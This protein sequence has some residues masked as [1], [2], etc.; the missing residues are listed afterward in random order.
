MHRSFLSGVSV[1]YFIAIFIQ[2][3]FYNFPNLKITPTNPSI[4]ISIKHFL[5]NYFHKKCL[6]LHNDTLNQNN[7]NQNMGETYTHID[8]HEKYDID[9]ISGFAYA[10]RIR[11]TQN[12]AQLLPIVFTSFL[13]WE[14]LS[15]QVNHTIMTAIGMIFCKN[16]TQKQS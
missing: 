15:E 11:K 5:K 7:F 1:V 6:P 8:L 3:E 4:S 16:R 10:Q 12:E 9:E 13:S 14:Q 2:H